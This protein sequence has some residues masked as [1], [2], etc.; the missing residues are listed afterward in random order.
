VWTESMLKELEADL[1]GYKISKLAIQLP[2]DK[3]FQFELV[4]KILKFRKTEFEAKKK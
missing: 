3:P 1:K 4:K 2:L